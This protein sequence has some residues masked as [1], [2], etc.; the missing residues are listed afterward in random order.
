M[1]RP[2]PEGG[3]AIDGP[4]KAQDQRPRADVLMVPKRETEADRRQHENVFNAA[5]I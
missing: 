1:R 3:Y 2:V 5:E 4:D